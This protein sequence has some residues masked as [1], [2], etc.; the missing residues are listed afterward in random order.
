M[1]IYLDHNA[2][3]P[4][5]PEVRE[6]MAR[7]LGESYGNPSSPHAEGAAARVAIEA[8]RDQVASAIGLRGWEPGE[9][10]VF[11]AGASESNNAILRWGPG[12][13]PGS[14]VIS[15]T[16]EHPSVDAP[17]EDLAG[18]GVRVDRL[19]VNAEGLVDVDR[20]ERLLEEE[21]ALVS[22]LWGNNETGV[23]QPLER[24]AD[25]VR[26]RGAWLHVDATQV[27]GK[28]PVD[29]RRLPV[30]SLALSAHKLNGPKGVGCLYLRN[31]SGRV[32]WVLGGGQERGLRGGT[33]NVVGIVGFGEACAGVQKEGAQRIR[34]YGALRDRLWQGLCDRVPG[35]RRNGCGEHVLCNT[36]NVEFEGAAGD[37]LLQALDLEGV[38][39]SAGAAC[40]SG[41]I[42]ASHVL[43]AMGRS[44]EQAQASLRLSVGY[45]VDEGQIDR[46]VDLLADLVPRTRQA[47]DS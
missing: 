45:G 41:S 20:L 43:L 3:T 38:A 10:I 36:L 39:V 26:A 35:V 27:L 4:L 19:A 14:R 32:P 42:S 18:R 40:H 28:Y 2:T 31:A 1:R 11:T 5:R 7:A 33:E 17:L 8:A 15:T 12:S 24:I 29:V 16:V 34:D 6:A 22:V 37:V 25:A 30:D 44:P 23:L 9:R 46:A 13:V 47:H 21:T